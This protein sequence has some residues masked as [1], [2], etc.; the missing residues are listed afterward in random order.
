MA[1]LTDM[2]SKFVT[3]IRLYSGSGTLRVPTITNPEGRFEG[4]L[5]ESGSKSD[6]E[7]TKDTMLPTNNGSTEDVQPPVIQVQSQNPN[8][9]APLLIPFA[10]GSFQSLKTDR[11][12]KKE[13]VRL[14]VG[15]FQ[16]PADFVVVDFEPDPRVPLILG[17]IFLKTSRALIDVYEGEITIRVGKEAISL[18]DILLLEELLNSE[19]LP[20]LPNHKIIHPNSKELNVVE[21]KPLIHQWMSLPRLNSG[22]A[23]SLEYA[24]LGRTTTSC[25]VIMQQRLMVRRRQTLIK[26]L[27]TTVQSQKTGGKTKEST[28]SSKKEVEK[29]LTPDYF[30]DLESPWGSP[31]HCVP[32]KGGNRSSRMLIMID[33]TRLTPNLV[34]KLGVKR[35]RKAFMVKDGIVLGHKNFLNQELRSERAKVKVLASSS[36][37][38]LSK[39]WDL[40][41]ELMCDA[42]DFAIGAVLGQRKNNHFQPIHYASKTMTEAQAYY[43]MT[44]KELLAVVYAFEKF[45]SYLVLSKSI[46]YTD[47]SAI[48]YLFAKKDAKARLMRSLHRLSTVYHP[49][50][51]G[52][53]EVSNRGLKRILERTSDKL[54][55]ALWAFR[56]AYKTPIRC[57]PYKLVYGKA[58]HLPVELEHKAY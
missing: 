35:R 45:R 6:T 55:D 34:L 40:P 52:Q 33:P 58:C 15:K 5:P 50:T 54:D 43:T 11:F 42:S 26:R 22:L 30:I 9:D 23:T 37:K 17:R 41:F 16:F 24:F 18:G 49:Q 7:V 3:L 29:F 28:T 21:V 32:K 20:P 13:P 48:K 8:S 27:R 10:S 19:P 44:E 56:T 25:P 14:M 38:L 1:N 4:L 31:I 46:V 57:T 12:A 2:L 36:P 51:S 39:D 53:V 47:H